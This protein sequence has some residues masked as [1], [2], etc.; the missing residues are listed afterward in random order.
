MKKIFLAA[1]AAAVYVAL[2]AGREDIVRFREMRRMS[3]GH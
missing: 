2:M 3:S 1:M